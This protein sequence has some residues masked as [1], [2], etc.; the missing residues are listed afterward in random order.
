MLNV[1]PHVMSFRFL[2][3]KRYQLIQLFR[4][5]MAFRNDCQ[6]VQDQPTV[7]NEILVF[8]A[9]N[10]SFVLELRATFKC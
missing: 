1:K 10:W 2:K 6:N 7:T 5:L 9:G 4:A 8:E 3:K